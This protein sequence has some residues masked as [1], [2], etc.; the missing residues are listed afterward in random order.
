MQWFTTVGGLVGLL[1][2]LLE[3][4]PRRAKVKF[5]T[6]EVSTYIDHRMRCFHCCQH[7]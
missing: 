1:H 6:H 7:G 5:L 3:S 2:G 4:C